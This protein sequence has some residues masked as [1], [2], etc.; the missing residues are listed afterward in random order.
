MS[1]S[2]AITGALGLLLAALLPTPVL[3]ADGPDEAAALRRA[4]ALLWEMSEKHHEFTD[5]RIARRVTAEQVRSMAEATAARLSRNRDALAGLL[6]S[7]TADTR[8]AQDLTRFLRR[9]PD[10]AAFL[11][12]LQAEKAGQESGTHIAGLA[13]QVKDTR[14]GWRTLFPFFRP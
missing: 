9:W 2:V 12:D 5:R 4:G 7:L 8:F 3:R 10:R 11:D 14:R 13:M 6:P 1:R